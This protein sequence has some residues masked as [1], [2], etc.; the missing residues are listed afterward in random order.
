MRETCPEPG[1]GSVA[2]AW[3][4]PRITREFEGVGVSFLKTAGGAG[5]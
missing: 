4:F 2:E 5:I 1:A 3:N